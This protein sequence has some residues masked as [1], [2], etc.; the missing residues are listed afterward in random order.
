MVSLNGASST[1][2]DS[3]LQDNQ[4]QVNTAGEQGVT[5]PDPGFVSVSGLSL[6]V[7]FDV[8]S[9][10]RRREVCRHLASS[11]EPKTLGELA[12]HIAA[13]ENGTPPAK[14]A[15]EDRKRVYISLYQ[16]NLPALDDAGIIDFDEEQKIVRPEDHFVVAVDCLRAVE[17][18]L[19]AADDQPE[20][21]D[22]D[23]ESSLLD[24]VVSLVRD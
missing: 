5:G 12:E 10:A 9:N 21:E 16:Y 18:R 1:R 23:L 4:R 24:R 7:F 17:N 19:M 15:S 2:N 14:L 20:K 8:L 11:L 13:K 22:R 6:D 3:P